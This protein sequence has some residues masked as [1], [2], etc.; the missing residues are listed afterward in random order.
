[1]GQTKLGQSTYLVQIQTT[2]TQCCSLTRMAKIKNSDECNK[3]WQSVRR[4][5]QFQCRV[6]SATEEVA[7]GLGKTKKVPVPD[8]GVGGQ[9]PKEFN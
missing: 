8:S 3:C 1:M 9:L 2:T 6:T 7:L 4:E 5:R